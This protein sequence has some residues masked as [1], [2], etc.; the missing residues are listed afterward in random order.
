MN[1]RYF[2]Y[3]KLKMNDITDWLFK[4]NFCELSA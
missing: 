2:F 3:I 4:I 1:I